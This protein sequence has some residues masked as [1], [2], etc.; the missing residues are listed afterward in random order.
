MTA[1][2][3]LVGVVVGEVSEGMAHMPPPRT[4]SGNSG[5]TEDISSLCTEAGN[6]GWPCRFFRAAKLVASPPSL[7]AVSLFSD[8]DMAGISSPNNAQAGAVLGGRYAK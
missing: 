8:C 3:L 7:Y 6:I 2:I 5:N 1:F 4:N